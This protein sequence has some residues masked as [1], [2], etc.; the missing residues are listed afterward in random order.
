ML[1]SLAI[2]NF[3]IIDELELEFGDGF[4]AITGETGAGKSIL[5]DA[6]S[7]LLGDRADT[8]LVAEGADRA[9][10]SATFELPAG[11][12]AAD[13]LAEQALDDETLVLRRVIPAEGASRAWINGQPAAIGQLREVGALLVE[14][15][16]QHEHQQL[17][18]PARQRDWLDR[19]ADPS[20]RRRVVETAVAHAQRRRE[21]D[22]LLGE[23]GAGEDLDYL[24]YQLAELDQLALEDGEFE[25]LETR[26]RRLASVEELQRAYAEAIEAIDGE[27]RSALSLGHAAQ[28][29]LEPLAD[30][31]PALTDVLE[32]LDTARVN[33]GE[34]AAALHRL[35]DD[36]END[37]ASLERVEQRMSTAIALARKHGVEP[38]RL[39]DAHRR[40]RE[41]LERLSAFDARRA[42]AEQALKQAAGQ[43]REAARALGAERRRVADALVD[44]IV[45]A[46]SELG[47]AD[48][49][50]EF[51]IQH[52]PERAVAATGADDVELLFSANPGQSPAPLKR[53]ASGGELSRLGL[54]LIIAGG[55][56][57]EGRVRIFDEID[58]G[59][60]GETAHAVGR[61]LRRASIGG[62]A[63]C[64]THL[65]QVAACADRQFRVTKRPDG[66][67]TR[68]A[69]QR[70]DA[71]Q[72]IVE[73]AR[74]LGSADAKTGREHARAMLSAAQAGE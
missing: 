10:L 16:G 11:H 21:L 6:L 12:A 24:R 25:T 66:N 34:A 2:R 38:A 33:L 41:R 72:R 47:M 62:Q 36:L 58:A 52:D 7:Q 46:L 35:G 60:G 8:G 49:R 37:P 30:R 48:A 13:W 19:H 42:E 59:V 1:R 74:M 14:V 3:T 39:P 40:L 53:V 61:F 55:D 43:W 31:E 9:D 69:V 15:H 51:H 50:V 57:A 32:M 17:T 29:V 65:A 26:Q 73:L 54:A 64:V 5:V 22:D 45:A 71:E 63:F 67:A 28:R 18:A 44:R 20:I 70:L 56:D 27:S 4:G 68:V 23:F